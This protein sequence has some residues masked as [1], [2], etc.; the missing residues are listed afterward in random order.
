MVFLLIFL[1]VIGGMVCILYQSTK[2]L[3][4]KASNTG[5]YYQSLTIIMIAVT[6]LMFIEATETKAIPM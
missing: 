1:I 6:T 3:Y 5:S 4:P 2:Y